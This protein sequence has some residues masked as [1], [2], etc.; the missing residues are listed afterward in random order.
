MST[1]TLLR[2]V[3]C[4]LCTF[5][6]HTHSIYLVLLKIVVGIWI[7]KVILIADGKMENKFQRALRCLLPVENNRSKST[8]TEI[9]DRKADI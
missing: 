7:Q 6:P 1:S 5:S 9:V 4:S 2:A 8:I 3:V